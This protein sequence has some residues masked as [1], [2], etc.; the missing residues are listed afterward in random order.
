MQWIAAT[1]AVRSRQDDPSFKENVMSP[2]ER[3]GKPLFF[4][5][6]DAAAGTQA[7]PARMG[8]SLR[9]LA[10]ALSGSEFQKEALVASSHTGQVWRLASDEGPYLNGA[11]AAPCP[12][13]LLTVGMISSYANEILALAKARGVA[14]RNIRLTQDNYYTME[15]SLAR[16]TMTGGA[17]PV[18]LDA[19]IDCDAGDPA[20][21]ELLQDAVAASPINGL[22]RGVHASLFTLTRNGEA[23]AP[24]RVKPTGRPPEPDPQERFEQVRPAE[25][26]WSDLIVRK[27]TTP[28]TE[29]ATGGQGSS[30]SE[31]Q[32]RKLH[33]R[34][35]CT[36]RRDGLKEIRQLL[37]NPQGSVF[38][39]LSDEAPQNGGLGRAPDAHS[40]ISA[41]IAFCFMTQAGRYAKVLGKDLREY[42]VVQDTHFSLGGASAGVGK[43]GAADPVETH[44]YIDSGEPEDFARRLLDMS[45]QTCFLHALCRTDLKT[46][47]RVRPFAAQAV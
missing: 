24:D 15:G 8:D 26:D 35:V 4:K 34:G 37:Y 6:G 33:V 36:L 3:S 21:S 5:A 25:G 27:G 23:L 38:H 46:K 45:E 7:P 31:H 43:P 13:S 12:L 16:G 2:L 10:R 18:E 39:F 9:T 22:M 28:R 29:E 1:P 47:L 20:L 44:L 41:G 19:E 40:Y 17:L 32:S 11:D 30:L 42:R 14:I